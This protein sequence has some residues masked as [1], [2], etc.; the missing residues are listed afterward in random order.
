MPR[1]RKLDQAD[2]TMAATNRNLT[3]RSHWLASR[4]LAATG[5]GEAP[6]PE[7]GEGALAPRG[8]IT[9]N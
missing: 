7:T 9:Y 5:K 2:R 4:I 1:F 8:A 3:G 6:W